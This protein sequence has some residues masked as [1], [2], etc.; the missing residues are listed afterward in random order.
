M[1]LLN[2][3]AAQGRNGD[4]RLA[5]VTPGEVVIP[6]EVAAI[7]PDQ[8]LRLPIA[9]PSAPCPSAQGQSP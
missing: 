9:A 2:S 7:R 1:G 6:K 4:T 3:V 5:H 8:G